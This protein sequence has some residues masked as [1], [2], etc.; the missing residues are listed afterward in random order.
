MHRRFPAAL[1]AVGLL[2]GCANEAGSGANPYP[3]V[4]APM[5]ETMP[6]PPVTGESL[7]WQPGHWDWNGSGYVWR[8]GQ[9]VP[10]AGHGQLWQPGWWSRTGSGWSW[11][12]AHWTS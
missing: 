11:Q 9:Y 3:P 12:P 5:V 8:P 7:D 4:P 2:A 10:A 1:F 6:K